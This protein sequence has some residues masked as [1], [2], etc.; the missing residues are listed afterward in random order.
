VVTLPMA[1]TQWRLPIGGYP[2]AVTLPMAVTQWRLPIGGYLTNGG[3]PWRLPYLGLNNSPNSGPIIAC[4]TPLESLFNYLSIDT[5]IDSISP[6]IA[7]S[8]WLQGDHP[9]VGYP[10]G[11]PIWALTAPQ[12]VTR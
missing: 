6:S 8:L 12:I 2:M 9:T 11:Y 10:G 1:V 3:Y 7:E 5:N 4:N